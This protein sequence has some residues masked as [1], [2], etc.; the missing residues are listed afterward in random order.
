MDP[1]HTQV[2]YTPLSCGI[3][4]P[5]LAVLWLELASLSNATNKM[6]VRVSGPVLDAKPVSRLL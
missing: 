6:D 1:A 5:D 3:A 4:I 2:R